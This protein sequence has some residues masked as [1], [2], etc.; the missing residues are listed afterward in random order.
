MKEGLNRI[1]TAISI[2]QE[3]QEG[4]YLA[5]LHRIHAVLLVA[6]TNRQQDI[7]KQFNMAMEH[8]GEITS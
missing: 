5:E 7:K 4:F 3:T 8:A 1:Q 6:S 2:S